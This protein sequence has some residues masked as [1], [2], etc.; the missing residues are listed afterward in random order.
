MLYYEYCTFRG[1]LL[2]PY[3]NDLQDQNARL[4]DE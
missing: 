1:I 2:D 4:E 3:H